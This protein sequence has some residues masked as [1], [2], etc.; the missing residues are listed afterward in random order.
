[1]LVRPSSDRQARTHDRVRHAGLAQRARSPWHVAAREPLRAGRQHGLTGSRHARGRRPMRCTKCTFGGSGEMLKPWSQALQKI[2]RLI[3]MRGLWWKT[4][5]TAI[6]ALLGI[7]RDHN[8]HMV[9]V[10]L[11]DIFGLSG[12]ITRGTSPAARR[13]A[14]NCNARRRCQQPVPRGSLCSF[15]LFH[16][17]E[18]PHIGTHA[19]IPSNVDIIR[20]GRDA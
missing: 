15:H 17:P 16:S 4:M 18:R 2:F 9:R 5:G 10:I 19:P 13:I 20:H 7:E 1:M 14:Q 8:A 6:R 12:N 3:P 11:R